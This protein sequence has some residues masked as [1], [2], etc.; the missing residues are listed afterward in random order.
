MIST[1]IKVIALLAVFG[2]LR[3]DA[4]QCTHLFAPIGAL[5]E[6][7]NYSIKLAGDPDRFLPG[8]LYTGIYINIFFDKY[9]LCMT[10]I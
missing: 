1:M 9:R 8:E 4:K 2:N 7:I 3:V 6:D 5:P 10:F